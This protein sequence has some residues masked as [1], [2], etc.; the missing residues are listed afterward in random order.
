MLGDGAGHPAFQKWLSDFTRT[1]FQPAYDFEILANSGNTDAWNKVV[2]TFCER[3]E[4]ILCEEYTFSS[5]QT[6]WIPMGCRGVPVAMDAGGLSAID[7]ERV[8]SSW[9]VTHPGIKRP[10]V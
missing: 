7:L 9:N 6:V 2:K 1:V 10:H 3:G 4:Y 8:L 5:A